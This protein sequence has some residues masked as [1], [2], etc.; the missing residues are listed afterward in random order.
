[1]HGIPDS[2]LL[3]KHLRHYNMVSNKANVRHCTSAIKVVLQPQC[4]RSW[5]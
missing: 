3:V 1:M 2:T 4:K 5:G